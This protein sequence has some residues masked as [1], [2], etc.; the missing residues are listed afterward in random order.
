VTRAVEVVLFDVGG[1]LVEVAGVGRLREWLQRDHSDEDIWSLWLHSDAVREFES[2]RASA[3]EFADNLIREMHLPVDPE[4]LLAEFV[5]WIPGLYPG[6]LELLGSIS[7]DVRRG[8]LSNSNPL[9]WPRIMD[10]MGLARA[11]DTHFV[12]HLTG[13]IKPDRGAFEHALAELGCRP[14]AVVFV[15]D[16]QVNVDAA[17]CVGIR[18]YRTQGAREARRVLEECGLTVSGNTNV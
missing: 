15:D 17:R 2:G 18:A 11:I 16:N 8:T 13:R 1:V 4:R 7:R 14:E 12:S 3:R 5:E 6:A 9:H 10:D